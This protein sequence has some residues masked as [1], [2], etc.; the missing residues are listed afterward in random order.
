[1]T[2]FTDGSGTT[3][4]IPKWTP[5][6]NTLGNSLIQE[7]IFNTVGVNV[8]PNAA[9]LLNVEGNK[10]TGIYHRNLQTSASALSTGIYGEAAGV[11]TSIFGNVG[12]RGVA[13]GATQYNVGLHGHG[14]SGIYTVLPFN[15]GSVGVVGQ[16]TSS[17][18]GKDIATFAGYSTSS[19]ADDTYGIYLDVSNPGAGNAYVGLLKDGTEGTGKVLTSDALGRATWQTP[20]GGTPEATT[21]TTTNINFTGQTI[22]YNAGSPGTGNITENLSGAKLGL[23]QKIYH[24]DAVEPT[25]PAGWV[26]MGDAIYFT[27]TLNIIY[28]EWAGGSRVEYWYVQEQ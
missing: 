24:N 13:V 21:A 12:T 6:G 8:T 5:D 26:L 17:I 3:N 19:H 1:M 4:Y 22:Y 28:A 23:V 15:L 2:G 16:A 27:S 7:S 11:N 18:V 9:V 10:N 20:S 25:Y 14:G